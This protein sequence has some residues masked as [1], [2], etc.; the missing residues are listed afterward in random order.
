MVGFKEAVRAS[1]SG[2]LRRKEPAVSPE[3]AKED[4]KRSIELM[5]R[6][7][8]IYREFHAWKNEASEQLGR[9]ADPEGS[10]KLIET[11]MKLFEIDMEDLRDGGKK[12]RQRR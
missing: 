11:P 4:E 6:G 10:R 7:M 3:A 1:F 12:D 9:S 5:F 2:M 8:D